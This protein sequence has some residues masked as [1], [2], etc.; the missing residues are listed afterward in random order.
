MSVVVRARLYR[1]Y[2]KNR[3]R[4]E[5][6]ASLASDRPCSMYTLPKW[7]PSKLVAS[8]QPRY[9]WVVGIGRV[10]G[11]ETWELDQSQRDRKVGNCTQWS[12]DR[13]SMLLVASVARSL[14]SC[15]DFASRYPDSLA[16]MS[17]LTVS[18][19]SSARPPV[20]SSKGWKKEI[21]S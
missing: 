21:T 7:H 2:L 5:K 11:I 16:G 14:F 15:A 20:T 8:K 3:K 12:H 4:K 6:K 10:R 17:H 9:F 19:Q 13:P 18:Q 1:G